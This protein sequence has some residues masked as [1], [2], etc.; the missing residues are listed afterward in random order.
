MEEKEDG[1]ENGDANSGSPI[2]QKNTSIIDRM[3]KGDLPF[4]THWS[5]PYQSEGRLVNHATWSW[6]GWEKAQESEDLRD[7]YTV[8]GRNYGLRKSEADEYWKT[9]QAIKTY[10]G[11]NAGRILATGSLL[12]EARF[13]AIFQGMPTLSK[14]Y[15]KFLSR[16]FVFP[17]GQNLHVNEESTIINRNERDN[18][19]RLF[20]LLNALATG[21]VV[22]S[23]M[24]KLK[25]QEKVMVIIEMDL[26]QNVVTR[27]YMQVFPKILVT[28]NVQQLALFLFPANETAPPVKSKNMIVRIYKAAVKEIHAKAVED[29]AGDGVYNDYAGRRL[30]ELYELCG[31]NK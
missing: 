29:D 9:H 24:R 28:V 5:Y 8:A 31:G 13:N 23:W 14:D 27:K 2:K 19:H 12:G 21:G 6:R 18:N 20:Y 3:W 7:I 26:L 1:S 16:G 17:S 25:P 4:V 15:I 30:D 10:Y 22:S 11:R